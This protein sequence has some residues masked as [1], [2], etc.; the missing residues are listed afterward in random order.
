VQFGPGGRALSAPS[1][2][3]LAADVGAGADLSARLT[4]SA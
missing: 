4:F 3:S 1:G 2:A